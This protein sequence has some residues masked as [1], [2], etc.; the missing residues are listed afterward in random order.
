MNYFKYLF[1]SELKTIST[2]PKRLFYSLILPLCLF[3]YMSLILHQRV[4]RDLPMAFLD[5]DQS[6]M[7]ANLIRMLDATPSISMAISVTDEAEA[8]RLIQQQKVFGFIEIPQD[9]HKKILRG[10]NQEVICYV[11]GQFLMPSGLISKDFQN[12]LGTLS[13]GITLKKKMQTGTQVHKAYNEAKPIIVDEHGLFNPFGNNS[14][15]L[16]VGFF[17]MVLQM[18]TLLLTIYVIGVE[19]KYQRGNLWLK[20]SGNRPIIALLGKVLP[21]TFILF[22][23]AMWMNYLLFELIGTPLRISILN[24]NLISFALVIVYQCIGITITSFGKDLRSALTLG[25]AL[26]SLAFSFS[27]YTFPMEGLPKSLQYISNIFPFTHFLEYYVGRAIKGSMVVMTWQ[28][29]FSLVLFIGIFILGYP[30]FIKILKQGGYE[31]N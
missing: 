31:K 28:P 6:P 15:F 5:K 17:P 19:F 13:A 10:S 29:L 24:V 27:G 1:L 30:K 8:K 18:I 25:S 26:A 20:K 12:T 4:P 9:F 14:F 23:V 7:S 22:C 21:Y 11:N 3:L 2:S 16:L